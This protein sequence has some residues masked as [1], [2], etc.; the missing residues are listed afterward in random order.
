MRKIYK[1]YTG[2]AVVLI[3]T[4]CVYKTKYVCIIYFAIFILGKNYF[5][6]LK[7]EGLQK[8]S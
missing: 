4:V 5:Q 1:F 3:I 2:F 8:S 7:R 6:M